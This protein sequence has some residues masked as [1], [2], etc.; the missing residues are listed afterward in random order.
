MFFI[1]TKTPSGVSTALILF[2]VKTYFIFDVKYPYYDGYI[3]FMA[4][5]LTLFIDGKPYD[6]AKKHNN[7]YT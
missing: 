2:F 5:K 4:Y 7:F 6:F 3:S 1:T